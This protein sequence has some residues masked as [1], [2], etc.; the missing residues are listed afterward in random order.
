MKFLHGMIRVKDIEKSLRFYQDF[1]GLK[2]AK[3]SEL[4]DCKLYFL[5][6]DF[7]HR[8]IELTAN[9]ETPEKYELGECFGHFAFGVK[10]LDEI[11]TKLKEF[12]YEWLWE[13][14]VLNRVNEPNKKTKIAFICDPDGVEIE[15]I[16]KENA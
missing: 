10:S 5:E 7:G 8:A 14:F 12:G 13:P 6:D 16:E 1:L 11:G 9:F 15:L 4:E 2:L 3:V